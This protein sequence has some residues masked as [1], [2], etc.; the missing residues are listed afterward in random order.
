MRMHRIV[1]FSLVA[2]MT[3]G[4]A[5]ADYKIVKQHH[6]DGFS[7][8]GQ[9]NPPT[10]EEHVTWVG[11][12]KMRMDQGSTSTIVQMEAKK[13]FMINHDDKTI[14]RHFSQGV[15]GDGSNLRR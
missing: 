12:K 3:A 5:S 15:I 9:T 13:M 11:D 6:Q 1:I 2:L 14:W 4:M 8:M 7:M 10:D